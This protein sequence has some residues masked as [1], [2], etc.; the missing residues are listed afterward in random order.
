MN[1]YFLLFFIV[2]SIKSIIAQ[3]P[4]SIHLSEKEGLPDVEFYDVIEDDDGFVWFAADKGL[5]KYDGKTFKKYSHPKKRG[6]SVFYLKKDAKGRIWCNNLTGQFF[7]IED[8]ALHLFADIK[9][10]VG[11]LLPRYVIDK[12]KLSIITG[13]GFYEINFKNKK[14]NAYKHF[15]EEVN[16]SISIVRNNDK[17]FYN[18]INVIYQKSKEISRKISDISESKIQFLHSA[19]GITYLVTNYHREKLNGSDAN[20]YNTIIYEYNDL[21][22]KFLKKEISSY[23]TN[24]RVIDIISIE[25]FVWFCTH[26]GVLQFRKTA[27][28][29]VYENTLFE[30]EFITKLIKDSHG[31]Y[32]FSTLDN[33]FYIIPN[34][35]IK[36]Y[37]LPKDLQR[38]NTIKRVKNNLIIGTSKGNVGV[39]NTKNNESFSFKMMNSRVSGFAYSKQKNILFISQDF[40]SFIWDFD[41]GRV[42][43]STRFP[44]AKKISLSEKKVLLC[45]S[46]GGNYELHNLLNSFQ[47]SNGLKKLIKP[48]ISKKK[49]FNVQHKTLRGK[50]A[51]THHYSSQNVL[52]TSYIDGFFYGRELKKE[53][54]IKFNGESIYS[55][56]LT[57]TSDGV[58]WVST[59]KNGILGIKDFK[60]KY[61]FTTSE[62]LL[63]NNASKI[64][65][66]GKNLIIATDKGLQ[67]YDAEK[68]SI[69]TISLKDELSILTVSGI[70]SDEKNIYI[71]GNNGIVK[72]DKKN[73]LKKHKKPKVYFTSILVKDKNEP[74]SKRY[75]LS[76]KTNRISFYFNTNGFKSEEKIKYKYRLK[77]FEKLWI[78]TKTGIARYPLIPYGK[79]VFQVK[80]IH[81]DGTEGNVE[82]ILINT[83]KPFW[84]QWWFYVVLL[85]S[86]CCYVYLKFKSLFKRQKEL[87]E[88]EKVDKELVMSQLENLRSQMNPHFV[89][90]ALNSIQEYIFLNEKYSATLY[91]SKFA[92]LIRTYLNHSKEAEISLSEELKT[93]NLYLELEKDRFEDELTIEITIGEKLNSDIIFIPSLFIQPY[94]ENSIKHGLFHKKGVK[95]LVVNFTIDLLEKSLKCTVKDNGIG[96]EASKLINI[97]RSKHHKSFFSKANEN[98]ISLLNKSRAKKITVRTNDLYDNN[99]SSIGTEIIIIIPLKDNEDTNN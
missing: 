86:I 81:Q 27:K 30:N 69:R 73:A 43:V 79:Y 20:T 90:N 47:K 59:F 33:G 61:V 93:L 58:I 64:K 13:K 25:N 42:H 52:Y 66:D 24:K 17:T 2:F 26:K 28:G 9:E 48:I 3:H 14:I 46:G 71:S 95:K 85:I 72:I 53:N 15:D 65:G 97:R 40:G 55:G 87:I 60:I 36:K 34:L 12:E 96:R 8:D 37:A 1:K 94:V 78:T 10:K 74:I 99:K 54:E 51:Y 11:I 62:G 39:L 88:K 32:W 50:R 68:K 6:L 16:N 83:Q 31:N 22:K 21:K 70:E 4:V 82:E 89:F 92:K 7:Y 45:S 18:S 57:E 56:D 80:A 19:D 38:I 41:S 75:R 29:L 67:F 98:R 91:L 84:L 77:N 5:Y 76:Y 63:S 35:D 49:I 23:F 44:N